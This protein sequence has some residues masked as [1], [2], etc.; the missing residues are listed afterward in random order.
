MTLTQL[1]S[2]VKCDRFPP[3]SF[4]TLNSQQDIKSQCEENS[5]TDLC[6]NRYVNNDAW[7]F[8]DWALHSFW[9]ETAERSC[10][11]PSV[12]AN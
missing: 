2:L 6:Y 9:I 3:I 12:G 7:S 1:L 8:K 10:R 11:L 5:A 4:F